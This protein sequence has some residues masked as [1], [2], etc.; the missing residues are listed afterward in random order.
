MNKISL[1]TCVY[2]CTVYT[3]CGKSERGEVEGNTHITGLMQERNAGKERQESAICPPAEEA[4]N[5]VDLKD[6]G[7][8]QKSAPGPT[9][10]GA[11]R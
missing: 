7:W 1:V 9:A 8:Q 6:A 2:M 3:K 4:Y 10:V 11:V 5:Y